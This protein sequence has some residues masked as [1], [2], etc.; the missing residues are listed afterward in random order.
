MTRVMNPGPPQS[1]DGNA[2]GTTLSAGSN[3]SVTNKGYTPIVAG[4]RENFTL[5]V[6]RKDIKTLD[7][8]D[9]LI[10]ELIGIADAQITLTFSENNRD[11]VTNHVRSLRADVVVEADD[12]GNLHLKYGSP[13]PGM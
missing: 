5:V 3:T 6:T 8:A 2:E 9:D 7:G 4:P 11:Y 10:Q 12:Q 1:G 13:Q